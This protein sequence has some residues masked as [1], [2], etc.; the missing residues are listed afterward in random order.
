MKKKKKATGFLG[1]KVDLQKAYDRVDWN[2]LLHILEAFGCDS[3]LRL[4]VFRC[5]ASTNVKLLL[6][7][8]I[9]GQIPMERGIRQ[10]DP[11]SP[12]LFVL[13]MEL[14]SRMIIKLEND[15]DIQ[16]IRMGISALA[17]THLFFADDILIF[18][19]ATVAQASKIISCLERFCEWIR[20]IFSLSKSGC[21]F[22]S[23]VMGNLKADIKQCLNMKELHRDAKYLG[24]KLFPN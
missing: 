16:G 12:F 5:I 18:C 9:F 15:G 24:H 21:F 7:G 23:K 1:I 11:L 17:I 14:L 19:K 22:S 2:V 13:F 4:L 10:G 6:N 8:S 20:Q 3:K